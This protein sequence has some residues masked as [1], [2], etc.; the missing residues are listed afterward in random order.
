MSRSRTFLR[1]LA[2]SL[3]SG[4]LIL[5]VVEGGLR[6]AGYDPVPHL[7]DGRE[8]VVRP[9][10]DPELRYELTPGTGGHFFGCDVSI[11]Q[12]GFRDDEYALAKPEGVSRIIALGD[13]ITFGTGLGVDE[14]WSSYLR[15]HVGKRAPGTQVLNMGVGGYDTVQE[16]RFLERTGLAYDPDYVI[17]G[18]CVNDLATVSVNL[19]MLIRIERFSEGILSWSRTAQWVMLNHGHRLFA[20]DLYR[21]QAEE[22]ARLDAVKALDDPEVNEL[23][24]Q[25]RAALDKGAWG[26]DSEEWPKVKRLRWYTS[27]GRVL[28]VQKAFERLAALAEEHDFHACVFAVPFLDEE[29]FSE[30]WARCY[31]IVRR[32]AEGAGLEFLDVRPEMMKLGLLTLQQ[33][34]K[35][36][37][38]P[39]HLGHMA[40]TRVLFRL[41][42]DWEDVGARP[43]GAG[44]G[45][46]K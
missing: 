32:L 16:V 33:G 15:L 27:H 4:A 1:R 42:H 44:H 38:H 46:G 28:R 19:E 7:T 12:G 3:C 29:P 43:R 40:I 35:D 5:V 10:A 17:L 14:T 11:N 36:P 6:L 13:S 45:P 22:Q 25:V 2:I 23:I 8:L 26:K 9:T 31:E 34:G 30:T 37:V 20:R 24:A 21:Q 18:Y 39:N 41:S